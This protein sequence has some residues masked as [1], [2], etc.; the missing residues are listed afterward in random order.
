MLKFTPPLSNEHALCIL[1]GQYRGGGG[2]GLNVPGRGIVHQ[3]ES[4]GMTELGILTAPMF[5]DD[6]RWYGFYEIMK[7]SSKL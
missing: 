2:G 7:P 3:N 4:N 5:A 1:C 6:L